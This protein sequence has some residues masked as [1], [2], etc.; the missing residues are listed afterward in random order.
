MAAPAHDQVRIALRL[1]H[2]GV[3]QDVEDG[4]GDA[5][6]AGQV[7]LRVVG[8]V[9]IDE[10]DVAQY[11]EQV[12]VN[13]A[14]H[15]AIDERAGRRAADIELD[16]ALALQDAD[17]EARVPLEQFLAV[18]DVAAAIEY[19]K[20]TFAKHVVQAGAAGVEQ[21]ADFGFGQH[22]ELAFRRNQRVDDLPAFGG[23]LGIYYG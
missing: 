2:V 8:D 20:R 4:V 15:F 18:V 19:C 23:Q 11:G 1:Q 5:V 21:L 10:H 16:A 3:A 9:E 14:N 13:P 12:L 6:S 7:E 17:V 22:F